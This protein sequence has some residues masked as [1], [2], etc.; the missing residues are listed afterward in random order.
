MDTRSY[1]LDR[2]ASLS[3]YSFKTILASRGHSETILVADPRVWLRHTT[4]LG[5]SPHPL[6]TK[7]FTRCRT[8]VLH[9]ASSA[10]LSVE[11]DAGFCFRHLCFLQDTH[12]CTSEKEGGDVDTRSCH[13][14]CTSSL[15]LY[16]SRPSWLLGRP[17][18]YP[19]C[20]PLRVWLR[21]TIQFGVSPHSLRTK[22]FT[23]CGTIVRQWIHNY[24]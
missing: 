18:R 24:F 1:H 23:C 9:L 19:R 7:R 22:R 3:L 12:L 10:G 5:A 8:T 20:W 2:T 15:S 17:L 21:H 11:I 13:L 6:R 4:H 16:P 14:D